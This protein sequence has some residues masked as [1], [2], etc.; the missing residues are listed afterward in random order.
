M[1]LVV[2]MAVSA[3]VSA[4][5]SILSAIS[6]IRFFSF[7]VVFVSKFFRSC[8]LIAFGEKL[9]KIESKIKHFKLLD[10]R[11]YHMSVTK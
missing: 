7:I 6:I 8:R 2:V 1:Q 4:A 3:A 5:M 11:D 9:N 10:N